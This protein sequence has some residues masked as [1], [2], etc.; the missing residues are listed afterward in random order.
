MTG[1]FEARRFYVRA[2]R[3]FKDSWQD[4]QV[5]GSMNTGLKP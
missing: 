5:A 3:I 4:S 2:E 1:G